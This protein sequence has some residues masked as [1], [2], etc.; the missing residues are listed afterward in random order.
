[1]GH[2]DGQLVFSEGG[3]SSSMKLSAFLPKKI[4]ASMRVYVNV[5]VMI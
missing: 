4:A 5:A 2:L 1:M 3:Q